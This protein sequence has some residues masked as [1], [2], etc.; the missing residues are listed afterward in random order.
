M[1]CTYF[2]V[3][4]G[5][6]D[7]SMVLN[8]DHFTIQG[9]NSCNYVVSNANFLLHPAYLASFKTE[10][11]KEAEKTLHEGQRSICLKPKLL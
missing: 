10:H 2:G 9:L 5:L 11:T 4:I 8:V 7:D 6:K 3:C 1:Q